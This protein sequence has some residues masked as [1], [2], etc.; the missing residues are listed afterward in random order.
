[1]GWTLV[2]AFVVCAAFSIAWL[3][4]G[5]AV[6][7]VIDIGAVH[8][9]AELTQ[10]SGHT[11]G[12]LRLLCKGLLAGKA[13]SEPGGQ[14]ILDY[15]FSLIN[16]AGAAVILRLRYRD[17]TAR[18]L[19]LGMICSAGAFNLQAHA[20]LDTVGTMYGLR[21]DWWHVLLL[22]SVGGVAYIY[23]LVLFPDGRMELAHRAR[24]AVRALAALGIAGVA[25]L[26]SY[27]TAEYP[28]T[29]SFVVFFGLLIPV[30]GVAAQ[31]H[32][33]ATATSPE[34]RQQSRVLLWALVLAFA[35][36][37][38][39]GLVS[40]VVWAQTPGS[41]LAASGASV[42]WVL[43]G[44]FAIIPLA[45]LAALLRFRLWDIEKLFNRALVYGVL[46]AGATGLYVAVV[47][48]AGALTG[49]ASAPGIAVRGAGVAAA[50]LLAYPLRRQVEHVIDKV[51]YGS[52]PPP[53]E[54]LS[55]IATLS[56]QAR[57]E[58]EALPAIARVA[59]EGL[60]VRAC[61]VRLQLTSHA[62]LA[63][64]WPPGRSPAGDPGAAAD[65][66]FNGE[67]LGKLE[68]YGP[69]S[70]A[71]L[72]RRRSRL[73]RDLS[74]AAGP[75]L[76][77][78][79]LG[80]ELSRQLPEIAA[81]AAEIEA[82]RKRIA[83]RADSERRSL[84]RNLHDGAQQQLVAAQ[85][86]LAMAGQLLAD[87]DLAAAQELLT[88][89][90]RHMAMSVRDLEDLAGGLFPPVLVDQG[91]VAALRA[92]AGAM[93]QPVIFE[94]AGEIEGKRFPADVE[95]AV[96]FTGLEALQNVAK[97][98]PGSRVTVRM[99]IA[100]GWL[101]FTVADGGPGFDPAGAAGGTGLQ[102]MSD[103][104]AAVDGELA[105]RS[106]PGSGTEITAM[107]PTTKSRG[108]TRTDGPRS[109]PYGA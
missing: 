58:A 86:R 48:V 37:L 19:S 105:V 26:L 43:R 32:R 55:R 20:T 65:I 74:Q 42:F 31:L 73:L 72:G 59:V 69:P 40:I 33:Y 90:G 101:S 14:A 5:A 17:L 99:R 29:L 47:V 35:V 45:L 63:C 9:W 7:V 108:G 39:L 104:V 49:T 10:H 95:A 8:H 84:E 88:D 23:A 76:H 89:I 96:Y 15:L 24:W 83:A 22:H 85:V 18:L 51:A 98:A 28:H 3:A 54:V 53:H 79:R 41:R 102:G 92:Q 56:Q 36:P 61:R 87:G 62:Q 106:S 67:H 103:R 97:H 44:V 12:W 13:R 2:L 4:A 100:D 78:T 21:V 52:R 11:S 27:S 70:A 38:V 64:H 34:R 91:V 77:N 109:R 81:R 50:A 30:A 25:A 16:L 107:V 94:L 57:N 46:A 82:S 66:V 1:M 6:A 93:P 60:A 68:L 75:V 80:I 71:A